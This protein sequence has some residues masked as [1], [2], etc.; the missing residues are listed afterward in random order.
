MNILTNPDQKPAEGGSVISCTYNVCSAKGACP[1]NVCE[2]NAANCLE[3]CLAYVPCPLD[4]CGPT[5]VCGANVCGSETCIA[6]AIAV[7]PLI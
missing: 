3:G 4:A 2:C 5:N 7:K 6:N 1:P